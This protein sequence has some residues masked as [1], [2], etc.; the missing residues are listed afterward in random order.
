MT[1]PLRTL[2][3]VEAA[4]MLPP[5]AHSGGPRQIRVD[6]CYEGRACLDLY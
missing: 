2:N 1:E 4:A 6:P 5:Q 3:L